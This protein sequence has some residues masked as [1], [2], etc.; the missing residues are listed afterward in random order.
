MKKI[1]NKNVFIVLIVFIVIMISISVVYAILS[2]KINIT[3]KATIGEKTTTN[4]G[5]NV[6]YTIKNK[7][8]VD[9]KY[10]FQI[11]MSLEN[12]TDDIL[13]GW[14]ISIANP[15]NGEVLNYYNVNCK[16]TESI[17]EFSN[18]S[19]NAQVPSK[20]KVVFEF[21]IATT[22]PYYKPENIIINGSTIVS[23]EKPDEPTEPE[24]KKVEVEIQK[25]NQWGTENEYYTQIKIIVKNI[26]NKE[27]HS[28][29][30]D[31]N[32]ESETTIEQMWNVVVNKNS[33]SKYTI[34]N[35]EYN[36]VIQA[37]SEINFGGII[38]SKISENK[39][40]ILNIKFN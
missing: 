37:G 22:D 26:G 11:S 23:P 32:F 14:K 1:R 24:E 34:L 10:V 2:E 17:I 13:D 16:A 5:Y 8:T 4:K 25:E 20:G 21:Q 27:I 15:E 19:Y 40:E 12:N 38:K 30:F 36:G 6:T 33:D 3:G 28:W 29:Q 9:N 35:S 39:Y 7:W 31:I 18:V